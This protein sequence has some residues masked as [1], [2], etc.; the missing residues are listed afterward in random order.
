MKQFLRKR[1]CENGTANNILTTFLLTRVSRT[2][3][4]VVVVVVVAAASV[5]LLV[6]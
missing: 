2:I 5:V 4:V 6:L 1:K 3:V